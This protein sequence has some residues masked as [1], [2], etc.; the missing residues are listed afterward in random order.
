MKAKAVTTIVKGLAP[1]GQ[2]IL[3][4]LTAIRCFEPEEQNEILKGVLKQLAIDRVNKF[5]IAG[6]DRD[7]Y[8]KCLD[9]FG[10]IHLADFTKEYEANKNTVK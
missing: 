10:S 3:N 7:R 9:E 5:D 1:V 6:R 4:V 2:S 8:G